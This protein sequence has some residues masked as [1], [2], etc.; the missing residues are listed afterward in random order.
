M[1]CVTCNIAFSGRTPQIIKCVE[2]FGHVHRSCLP[3]KGITSTDY[4]RMKKYGE[5]FEFK[6]VN[7]SS[8]TPGDSH[9]RNSSSQPS[10][11]G[12]MHTRNSSS[13]SSSSGHKHTRNSSSKPSS[14]GHMHTRDSASQPSTSSHIPIR[15]SASQ[16]STSGLI[17]SASEPSTSGLITTRISASQT[18]SSGHITTKIT[19]LQPSLAMT[20]QAS[21]GQITTRITTSLPSSTAHTTTDITASLPSHASTARS[22]TLS[23]HPAKWSTTSLQNRPRINWSVFRQ[24]DRTNNDVEGWHNRINEGKNGAF[25]LFHL[26]DQ[27]HYEA[28]LISLQA[29]LMERG[30]K[31]RRRNK[32]CQQLQDDLVD[33]WDQYSNDDLPSKLLLEKVATLYDNYNKAGNHFQIVDD[34]ESDVSSD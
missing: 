18:S 19:A 2:C 9:T 21:I 8:N 6:C 17:T 24:D 16:P 5:S 30:E 23:F 32:A 3:G 28:T 22:I 12:H 29:K 33:L 13:Q 20:R 10:S 27:L 34:S 15:N 31:L 4:V 7:C 14:S 1:S 11:S 26:I 25:N